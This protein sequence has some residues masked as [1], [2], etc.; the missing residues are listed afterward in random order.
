MNIPM[1]T[2]QIT[3]ERLAAYLRG[4][5]PAAE[6]AEIEAWY[7]ASPANRR[8]MGE[9]YRILCL[10]DRLRAAEEVDVEG[11]LRAVKR[12]MRPRR[13]PLRRLVWRSAAAAAVVLLALGLWFETRTLA[14]RLERPVV[15]YTD[16]GE[17]SQVE[18]PD[19]T[20]LFS[21]E[22]RV[23]MSGEAY[24]EVEHDAASPFIVSSGGLDIKV[25]GTK[26]NIRNDAARHRVTTV[27]LEGSVA[28]ALSG[29]EEYAVR[30][31][32]AQMLLFDS[33]TRSMQLRVVNP[34]PLSRSEQTTFEQIV[35]E[36]ERYYNVEVRFMDDS[37]RGERFS[38]DFHLEDGIY[39]IMSVL[40]LTYKFHYKVNRDNIELYANC[41]AGPPGPRRGG[42]YQG[43][44]ARVH[45]ERTERT[46]RTTGT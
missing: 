29:S 7:D 32:P 18:L 10:N 41:P 16:L 13:A 28:A 12:R 26:F 11:S 14:E 44:D 5:L 6:A 30:L 46:I 33:E 35:S 37:L 1:E 22:R 45:T 36:L 25:L 42:R 3:E 21:R 9:V 19:G 40:Q 15:V 4:E 23:T 39:H 27:L 24:F 43:G 2:P 20:P 34:Q 38:G 31:R 17:R 8:T